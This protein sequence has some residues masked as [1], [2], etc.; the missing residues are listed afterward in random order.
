MN[1]QFKII[2]N[3]EIDKKKPAFPHGK[4]AYFMANVADA[5]AAA[6]KYS[7]CT[8][9]SSFSLQNRKFLF[10]RSNMTLIISAKNTSC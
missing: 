9:D 5:W 8:D 1:G 3:F 6:K 7:Y 4:S 2:F 10:C